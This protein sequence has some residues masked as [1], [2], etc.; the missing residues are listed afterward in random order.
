MVWDV[1]WIGRPA[2]LTG[3]PDLGLGTDARLGRVVILV[4]DVH[5]HLL[6]LEISEQISV[7]MNRRIKC[8]MKFQICIKKLS[9]FA[10]PSL[11]TFNSLGKKK[12][13]MDMR[14]R[15]TPQMR[16][17]PHHIPTQWRSLESEIV[18][19]EITSGSL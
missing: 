2:G 14:M 5:L 15:A 1:G 17:P 12:N 19:A 3:A 11:L 18:E 7:A 6:F 9:C 8:G 10:S 13:G 16:N 4:V